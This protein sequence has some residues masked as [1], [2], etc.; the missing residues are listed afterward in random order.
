MLLDRAPRFPTNV[1]RWHRRT[2]RPST[3]RVSRSALGACGARDDTARERPGRRSAHPRARHVVVAPGQRHLTG[4]AARLRPPPRRPAPRLRGRPLRRP[5]RPRPRGRRPRAELVTTRELL[6]RVRAAGLRTPSGAGRR[7]CT[8]RSSRE[9]AST[10]SGPPASPH[11]TARTG[12]RGP[13]GAAWSCTTATC[14]CSTS[15]PPPWPRPSPASAAGGPGR[16]PASGSSTTGSSSSTCPTA[17]CRPR[18]GPRCCVRT[19]SRPTR[20]RRPPPL[21]RRDG[22]LRRED[23]VGGPGQF[24]ARAVSVAVSVCSAPSRTTV[25]FTWLPTALPRIVAV[26]DS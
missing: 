14:P 10:S 9:S 18:G 25:S 7:S 20:T 11:R 19:R 22:G 17:P 21:L 13:S 4:G 15:S 2:P 6:A 8:P 23:P 26:S 3:G 1:G 12:S 16:R 5:R 24:S